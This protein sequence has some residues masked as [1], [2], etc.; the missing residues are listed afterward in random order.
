MVNDKPYYSSF[1]TNLGQYLLNGLAKVDTCVDTKKTQTLCTGGSLSW[2]ERQCVDSSLTTKAT[3]EDAGKVWQSVHPV[4]IISNFETYNLVES[5][6][7]GEMFADGLDFAANQYKFGTV[8][9]ANKTLSL[10]QGLTGTVKT[11][12]ILPK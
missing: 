8:N 1:D 6:A 12:I 7:D 5:G 11:I 2:S 9:I 4:Q 10:K 3:C